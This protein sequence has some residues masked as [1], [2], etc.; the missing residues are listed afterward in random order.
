MR[1][2]ILCDL[3]LEFGSTRIPRTD[4]D[5]IV[6]ARDIHLGREGRGWA[7]S[8]FPDKPVIYVLGNHEFYRHSLPELTDTLTRETLGSHIYLL[9]NRSIEIDGYTFL[10]CMLWT[11]FQLSPD[12]EGAMRTAESI[13][14]DM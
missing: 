9:A 11:D 5:V 13:M 6:L 10:G 1:V 4:A 8:Q 2:H 14:S 12:P 7:G 3:H